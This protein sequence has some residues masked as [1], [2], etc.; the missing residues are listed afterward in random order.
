M[1]KLYISKTN[2]IIFLKYSITNVDEY[3]NVVIEI[4]MPVN[5]V[6]YTLASSTIHLHITYT[7]YKFAVY[8]QCA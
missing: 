1:T 2:P 8:K 5:T 7:E 6:C 4:E 3:N